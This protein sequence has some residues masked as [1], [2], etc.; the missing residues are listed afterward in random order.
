MYS[1]Q[2]ACFSSGACYASATAMD[3]CIISRP[4]LWSLDPRHV[5]DQ[6]APQFQLVLCVAAVLLMA[7]VD[8]PY[9]LMR[10]GAPTHF[11]RS[12][13]VSRLQTDAQADSSVLVSAMS[14][15]ECMNTW[16]L[17][18]AQGACGVHPESCSLVGKVGFTR[19]PTTRSPNQPSAV[20]LPAHL[21][22]RAA[23]FSI[24][25]S[26]VLSCRLST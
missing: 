13:P 2:S 12:L 16:Q 14:V 26:A 19:L 15:A 25:A 23:T 22:I 20:M 11:T 18:Q 24:T 1:R 21:L 9:V 17:T 7:A 5:R 4:R 8:G 6:A 10:V 3:R